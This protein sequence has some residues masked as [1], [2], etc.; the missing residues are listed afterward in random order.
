MGNPKKHSQGFRPSHIG[1]QSHSAG[2]NKG[3][4]MQDQSGQH[5]QVIQTKGE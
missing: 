3:K 5:P 2:G 4:Q 1:T